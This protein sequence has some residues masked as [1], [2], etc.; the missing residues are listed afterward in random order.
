MSEKY[1]EEIKVLVKLYIL[2]LNLYQSIPIFSVFS[3][4]IL[5]FNLIF[6]LYLETYTKR[7]QSSDQYINYSYHYYTS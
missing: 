5:T 2:R 6:I 4:F 1:D 3:V 7:T